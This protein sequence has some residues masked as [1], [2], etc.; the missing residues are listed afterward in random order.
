RSP[1]VGAML[2]QLVPPELLANANAWLASGFQLSSMGGPALG[3]LVIAWTGGAEL[4][5]AG[6]ALGH[7]F[8]VAVLAT[9]P[10]HPAAHAGGPAR[11]RRRAAPPRAGATR[12]PACASSSAPRCCWAR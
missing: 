5:Y 12:S 4:A 2:P 8:F 3:G 10:S 11:R 9:L 1:A 6:A 7:L